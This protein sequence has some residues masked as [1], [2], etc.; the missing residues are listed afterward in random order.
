MS[1]QTSNA[2]AIVDIGGMIRVALPIGNTP[3]RELS[4]LLDGR[5]YH[6]G[7]KMEG[8][9]PFGSVKDRTAAF[10]LRDVERRGLINTGSTIIESTSGNLGVALANLCR[11][12][13]YEFIAVID[14][15]TTAE[16]VKRLEE[17]GALIEMVNETDE[18]GGYLLTRLKRVAD[19]CRANRNIVWVNQYAN[20]ANPLA[21]S[22]TTGPEILSQMREN[23]E[24]IFVPISTG[25]T[26]AG[27]SR[28]SRS[29]SPSTMIVAVDAEGSVAFGGC[30]SPR[31]L[32]GIGSSRRSEFLNSNTFD[33]LVFVSDAEAFSLCNILYSIT[34][35]KIG[36]SGGAAVAACL[37]LLNNS[38]KT[39]H[40]I[41]CICP[42]RG[43]NYNSSIFSE[44]WLLGNGFTG[45]DRKPP[46]YDFSLE[47]AGITSGH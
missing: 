23:V 9:N 7:L 31:K 34:G 13:G 44:D 41:V 33:E 36:G 46:L 25:G 14:P 17:S 10:L 43:E 38:M 2:N 19:L 4:V 27:I 22:L 30:S 21:H 35:L 1:G 32:T 40:R 20:S 45:L 12:K 39:F 3:I 29:A 15:K 8:E 5:H 16:N 11:L 28:F 47:A 26:I 18:M 24:A 42:D 37:R 6:I